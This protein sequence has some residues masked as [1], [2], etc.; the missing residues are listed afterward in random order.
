MTTAPATF[1]QN[2]RVTLVPARPRTR[3]WEID[4]L[5]GACI[6]LMILDH[7]TMLLGLYFGPAWFGKDMA[8]DGGAAFCRWCE[9]FH[10]STERDIA[11][12]IVIFV[13]FSISGI[14]SSFSRSNVRRGVIL[15]AVAM[16][17]TGVTYAAESLFAVS[18]IHVMFG[19]LHCFAACILI[20]ALTDILCR[21]NAVAKAVVAAAVIVT[22]ACLYY[23][24]TPPADTPIFF[25]PLFGTG[26]SGEATFF[27]PSKFSP[28]DFFPVI[29]YIAFF[30]AGTLLAPV[31]YPRRYSLLPFMD[32][33]W[34]RPV[35]FIGKYSIFFYLLHVV[36]LAAVLMLISYL[37]IT[38]G[39]W[40]LV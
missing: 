2:A 15:A 22:A 30:F 18:G 14:S 8:G 25:A 9:W 33:K 5:R 34:N 3:I 29:P 13:C 24:Y 39:D 31:L 16:L 26:V 36:V 32:G 28:G 35:C 37:F 19:V 17:Y 20:W 1:S 7:L 12:A 4:F 11:H 21:G 38:P 10:F 6:V 40:V 23:L 27:D